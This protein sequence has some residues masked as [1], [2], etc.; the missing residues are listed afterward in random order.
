M[1]PNVA[2]AGLT[3]FRRH[4]RSQ[5]DRYN[6]RTHITNHITLLHVLLIVKSYKLPITLPNQ[7]FTVTIPLLNNTDLKYQGCPLYFKY[8]GYLNIRG[9]LL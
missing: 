7:Y 6:G 2:Y 9:I 3:L 4:C 8:K 1:D 5:T